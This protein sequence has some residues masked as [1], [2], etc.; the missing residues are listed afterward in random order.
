M[1]GWQGGGR[2]AETFRTYGAGLSGV[3]TNHDD[4]AVFDRA[5]DVLRADV[6]AA[7]GMSLFI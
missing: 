7:F 5:I 1:N 2:M 3:S 4:R 6:T